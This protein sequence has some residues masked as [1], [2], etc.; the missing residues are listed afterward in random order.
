M[1]VLRVFAV[2]IGRF[3][4][5]QIDRQRG[6]EQLPKASVT[7]IGIRGPSEGQRSASRRRRARQSQL[8]GVGEKG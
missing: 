1:R 7:R 2:A 6:E 3:L 4:V 5:G 8:F